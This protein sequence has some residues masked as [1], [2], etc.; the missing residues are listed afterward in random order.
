MPRLSIL[1]TRSVTV[2]L[3]L[4]TPFSTHAGGVNKTAVQAFLA[5]IDRAQAPGSPEGV[6]VSPAEAREAV[7]T[8]RSYGA[9]TLEAAFLALGRER[10]NPAVKKGSVHDGPDPVGA[11]RAHAA[12]LA[13]LDPF[14]S[15]E[16]DIGLRSASDVAGEI[17]GATGGMTD[18]AGEAE[19]YG[20][21]PCPTDPCPA[22]RKR[23]VDLS[24]A[25]AD[26]IMEV[27]PKTLKWRDL[28]ESERVLVKEL[29]DTYSVLDRN[30]T[31]G[32]L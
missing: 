30:R 13:K 24:A 14:N 3:L 18:R 19:V 31:E 32:M 23:Y 17:F 28:S 29:K 7:T 5:E 16:R 12:V 11:V 6:R 8:L 10:T 22:C 1:A 27:L 20:A 9:P 2:G 4:S 26:L 15:V 21:D 25:G